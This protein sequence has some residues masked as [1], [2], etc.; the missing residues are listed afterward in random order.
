M[1]ELYKL[2]CSAPGERLAILFLLFFIGLLVAAI[3]ALWTRNREL[4]REVNAVHEL[5]RSLIAGIVGSKHDLEPHP[6]T[7]PLPEAGGR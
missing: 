5:Q 4:E 7:I 2:A 6:E 1:G 3:R